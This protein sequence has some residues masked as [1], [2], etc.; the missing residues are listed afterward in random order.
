VEKEN[1]RSPWKHIN[2]ILFA[3]Q[4][5][6]DIVYQKKKEE[7]DELYKNMQ[8]L[9]KEVKYITGVSEAEQKYLQR[10]L[11][12]AFKYLEEAG[13]DLK[14]YIEAVKKIQ[15]YKSEDK[16]KGFDAVKNWMHPEEN[17]YKIKKAEENEKDFQYGF[18]K[19]KIGANNIQSELS[20]IVNH[21]K[22]KGEKHGTHAENIVAL[23]MCGVFGA[24]VLYALANINPENVSVGAFVA[25]SS[26]T[27]WILFTAVV[28][29]LMFFFV[30]HKLK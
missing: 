26:P 4:D 13:K 27:L 24:T 1:L 29:F 8:Q 3:K 5:A 30:N 22:Q 9:G 14:G 20:A 17:D 25:G 16:L 12:K 28:I 7:I 23:S 15:K 2:D 6:L 21:Y 18:N 10:K 19:W 11:D